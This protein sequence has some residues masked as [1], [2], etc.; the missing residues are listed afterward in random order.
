MSRSIC[1]ISVDKVL[2]NAA[3]A[4]AE[5]RGYTRNE[6]LCAV[7]AAL[8]GNP[9]GKIVLHL[10]S[11]ADYE[12]GETPAIPAATPAE[13]AQAPAPIAV[14]TAAPPGPMLVLL[15][16]TPCE[17]A[18][19]YLRQGISSMSDTELLT[20]CETGVTQGDA[21]DKAACSKI[22]IYFGEVLARRARCGD[23]TE[24]CADYP[25]PREYPRESFG[26]YYTACLTAL[27]EAARLT[28]EGEAT[29]AL[30]IALREAGVD[31]EELA[32]AIQHRS[33]L[34]MASTTSAVAGLKAIF[35]RNSVWSTTPGNVTEGLQ[36]LQ[37]L[38][39]NPATPTELLHDMAGLET[40]EAAGIGN[41]A[42]QARGETPKKVKAL[43]DDKEDVA[44]RFK[45]FR[46]EKKG[47][48]EFV[49]V[50]SK[51]E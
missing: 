4:S 18:A 47:S 6:I 44:K 8:A 20:A 23:L 14:A 12:A 1:S 46:K 16:Q 15:G 36:V 37:A 3:K 33:D 9:R 24:L 42:L 38:A 32:D 2:W 11:A 35:A 31:S 34:A 21:Q 49:G 51:A 30:L 7:V 5:A 43:N 28:N 19:T 48:K 13:V 41:V 40:P 25:T 22:R 45:A 27:A 29:S 39:S 17:A 50:V 26:A 10:R